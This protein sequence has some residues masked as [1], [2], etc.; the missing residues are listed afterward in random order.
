ML[1]EFARQG[2]SITDMAQRVGG[3]RKTV[4]KDL[5]DPEPPRYTARPPRVSTLDPFKSYVQHRLAC[6]VYNGEVLDRAWCARGDDGKNTM[7]R[8]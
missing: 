1:R 3:D 8:A 5:A 4:R 2:L 6:G 7:L